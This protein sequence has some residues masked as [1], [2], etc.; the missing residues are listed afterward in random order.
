MAKGISLHIGL[1]QVDPNHYHDQY[2][3]PWNGQLAACEFDAQDMQAI[4]QSQGFE[5]HMLLT[6]QATSDNVI[7][8]IMQS[9]QALQSGDIF[10]MTY[11][12]HGGQ[13]P[14]KNGDEP[15]AMDET[16][17][18]YDRQ[19]IDDE[20][21]ALWGKFAAG[22]RILVLSDSCHSGSVVKDP[23]FA[24]VFS[25][26][27]P[28]LRLMPPDAQEGTYKS[29]QV[30]Y[31]GIQKDNKAGDQVDIKATVI[32]ISGC[33]DNQFSMDGAKN[34]LFTGTLL[35]VWNKGKYKSS[36]R[37]F[38]RRVLNRMPLYQSPNYFKVGAD[39]P[40]FENKRPFTI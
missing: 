40:L 15:D 26:D 22:V 37:R 17:C 29:N 25:P 39:N 12:G 18:L 30:L 10:F 19:V 4:A 5:T 31:D 1:N 13:V 27:G 6:T 14:D 20:L 16:W 33:Q 3:N 34:G 9:T 7:N 2:G 32:L 21:F 36:L 11:S 35:K 23:F 8:T 28:A 24:A 38:Y